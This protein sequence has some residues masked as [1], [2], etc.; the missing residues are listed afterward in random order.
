MN[1]DNKGR[2]LFGPYNVAATLLAIIY[3]EN[4]PDRRGFPGSNDALLEWGC[5][6]GLITPAEVETLKLAEK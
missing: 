4:H 1:S 2:T 3:V 5:R 6:N